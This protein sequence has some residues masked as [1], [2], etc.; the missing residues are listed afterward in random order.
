MELSIISRYWKDLCKSLQSTSKNS[1]SR[2]CVPAFVLDQVRPRV[3]LKSLSKFYS[4]TLLFSYIT[5]KPSIFPSCLA[6]PCLACARLY[7]RSHGWWEM[8][9]YFMYSWSWV[10][11]AWD[12]A[13]PPLVATAS[14]EGVEAA[15]RGCRLLRSSWC[16][17]TCVACDVFIAIELS[18]NNR[19][20]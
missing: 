10:S 18:S 16:L 20:H 3:M 12:L 1:L 8:V 17:T 2:V 6:W 13:L 5:H 7:A 15:R 4:T 14:D 19:S 9:V 11:S